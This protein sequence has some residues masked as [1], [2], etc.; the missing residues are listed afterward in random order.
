MHWYTPLLMW[1][2]FFAGFVLAGILA[3]ARLADERME[4]MK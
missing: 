4:R 2:S 3:S 1:L